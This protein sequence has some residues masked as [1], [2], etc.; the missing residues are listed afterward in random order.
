MI[1]R[2]D[3]NNV[4]ANIEKFPD[5]EQEKIGKQSVLTGKQ[6]NG[7]VNPD[8]QSLQVFPFRMV[9]TYRVVGRLCKLV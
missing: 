7:L 3:C 9:N 5:A 1:R 4:T 8:N 6:N 2:I